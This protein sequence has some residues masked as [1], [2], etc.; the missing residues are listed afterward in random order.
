[1]PNTIQHKRSATPTAVPSA[2]AMAL[3]ELFINTA[4]GKL[5]LKKGDG[6]VVDVGNSALT[7][8]NAMLGG[9]GETITV[10]VKG[11]VEVPFACDIVG[12][13]VLLTSGAG[14]AAAE[15]IAI[16]I[17]RSTYAVFATQTS[18]VGAGTKPG[19]SSATKNTGTPSGW[20]STSI[21]AGDILGFEIA[22]APATAQMCTIALRL[23]RKM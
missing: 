10:G 19:T 8:L 23:Q 9:G 5:F 1:M 11:H 18:I 20:T 13:T 12:W 21:A 4:D 7:S 22:T 16:D 17:L 14:A 3:G 2:G 6:A 15:T